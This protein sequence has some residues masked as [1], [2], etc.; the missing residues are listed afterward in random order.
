MFYIENNIASHLSSLA[1]EVSCHKSHDLEPLSN[2]VFECL[3][4][5]GQYGFPIICSL[6]VLKSNDIGALSIINI[7]GGRDI[8]PSEDITYFCKLFRRGDDVF[9]C[10]QMKKLIDSSIDNTEAALFIS[11][12]AYYSIDHGVNRD[13]DIKRFISLLYNFVS[14]VSN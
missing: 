2:K 3:K 9:A 13:T 7:L 1:N 4:S 10:S 14:N 5:G 6:A 8:M 12:C 11:Q